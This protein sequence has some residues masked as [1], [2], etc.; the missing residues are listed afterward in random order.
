MKTEKYSSLFEIF[1]RNNLKSP[2]SIY[3]VYN[4]LHYTY[5][6]CS[7]I[8]NRVIAYIQNKVIKR[9]PTIGLKFT[10]QF[11]FI[12]SYWACAKLEADIIL[13]QN[14]KSNS[15]IEELKNLDIGVD[16]ILSDNNFEISLE[17]KIDFLDLPQETDCEVSEKNTEWLGCV[18]FYSSGTT[19]KSKFI[20]TTYFQIVN[21][22]NCIEEEQLMPYIKGQNVLITAPIFHSYGLSC[23]IEY[24]A[25]N[26]KVLLPSRNN[27]VNPIQCLFDVKITEQITAIEGVPYFYQQVG[28]F[29][30]RICLPRIV[31][32][33]MGGDLVSKDLLGQFH[34]QYHGLT[35]SIRYGITEIPSIVSINYFKFSSNSN[36]RELM[37]I[38][39]IYNLSIVNDKTRTMTGE[40]AVEYFYLPDQKIRLLTGDLF[41]QVENKFSFQSRNAFI[42]YK[43][44]KIDPIEIEKCLFNHKSINDCR[45]V[46]MNGILTAELVTNDINMNLGVVKEYLKTELTSFLIPDR[47]EVVESIQRTKTGKIIRG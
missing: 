43:G 47:V 26:S 25:G 19:G 33:G 8:I 30:N 7:R 20:K 35:F 13:F 1:Q 3:L 21:A 31:H 45:V 17:D 29:L 24:T 46:L 41:K 28:L 39:S 40:L 36:P 15:E 32:L 42:K 38:P 5:A 34:A 37:K 27:Y 2:E 16:L 44:Y 18:Y 12:V 14:P 9:R 4:N 23:F 22:I 6:D 11:K 10:D